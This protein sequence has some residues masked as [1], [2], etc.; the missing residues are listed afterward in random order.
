MADRLY[1]SYWLRGFTEHNMLRHFE[2]ALRLVP[3]SRLVRSPS[4]LKVYAFEYAEPAMM[5]RPFELPTQLED[6]LAAAREFQHADAAYH[7]DTWW[8]VWQYSTEWKL[9]PS[10][11]S[12]ICY[13]P[14]FESDAEENLRLECG[15]DTQFLPQPGLPNAMF[16]AQSNIKGLLKLAHDLDNALAAIKRQLWTESGQN[17]AEVMERAFLKTDV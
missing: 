5:E 15:L 9:E 1:L 14:Q 17:F 10:R 12:I 3:F 6:V 16:I 8:D 13:G 7:L 4:V 2:R 11:L